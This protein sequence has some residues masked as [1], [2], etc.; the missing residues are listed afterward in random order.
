MDFGVERLLQRQREMQ[1]EERLVVID[2]VVDR[3]LEQQRLIVVT[4]MHEGEIVE[5]LQRLDVDLG[6]RLKLLLRIDA[7]A[8]G[9]EALHRHRGIELVESPMMTDAGDTMIGPEHD[10]RTDRCPD[11]RMGDR[12]PSKTRRGRSREK[13][14][15]KMLAPQ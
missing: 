12:R 6:E 9:I 2:R 11:M 8:I 4:E 13:N 14:A 1:R 7:V 15:E 5:V 3:L 10:L